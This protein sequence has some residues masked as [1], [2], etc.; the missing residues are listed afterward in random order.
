M[1]HHPQ[2]VA[3]CFLCLLSIGP[4]GALVGQAPNQGISAES[5]IS[6]T[7]E[8]LA[9]HL[10]GMMPIVHVRPDQTER[11]WPYMTVVDFDVIVSDRGDVVRADF[12]PGTMSRS[13]GD[14]VEQ[15]EELIRLEHFVP[16][17]RNGHPVFVHSTVGV[18]IFPPE[19]LPIEHVPFLSLADRRTLIMTLSR[20]RCLG[21]C[22]EYRVQIHGNGRVEYDGNCSVAIAG[23]HESHLPRNTVDAL[24]ELFKQADFFSLE[25][26]YSA[27]VLDPPSSEVSISFDGHQKKIIDHV[28][29]NVGMPDAVVQLEEAIDNATNS[30]RWIMGQ[31]RTFVEAA[32]THPCK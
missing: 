17:R 32:K 21:Y 14:V 20:S 31:S 8:E 27:P 19:R 13:H 16:F 7:D 11:D 25:D 9:L 22:A 6:V 3:C 5:A 12:Q 30:K 26:R 23:H 2:A 10:Q 15:V 4:V 28:G 1:T 18:P 24:F 29:E